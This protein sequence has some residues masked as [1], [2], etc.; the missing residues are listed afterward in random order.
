MGTCGTI[1]GISSYLKEKN[2]NIKII[3]M[4]PESNACFSGGPKGPHKIVGI[5]PGFQTDNFL[6]SKGRID[7]IITVSDEDAFTYTREIPKSEGL[8]VGI[9]SG[10]GVYVAKKLLERDEFKDPSK[11][12]VIL[13]CDSGER[14]LTTPGLFPADNVD[15]SLI[16]SSE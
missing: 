14:Y 9:T 4:E 13:F 3:G 1:E 16:S 7:E 15:D 11:V 10:A 2:P 12:I 5:G 6:R 8:L